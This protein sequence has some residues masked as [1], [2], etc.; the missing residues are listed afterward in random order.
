MRSGRQR[1]RR[2]EPASRASTAFSLRYLAKLGLGVGDQARSWLTMHC[3]RRAFTRAT[4]DST[5]RFQ[6][7]VNP[8]LDT[9]EVPAAR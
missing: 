5:L 4:S 1:D 2:H 8:S 7:G 9:V 3:G 6:L